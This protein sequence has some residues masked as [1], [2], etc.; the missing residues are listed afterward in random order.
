[1]KE[2]CRILG[3]EFSLDISSAELATWVHHRTYEILGSVDPYSDVK[4]IAME[5][6]LKLEAKAKTIIEQSADR[7]H[8]SMLCS[9]V[10]NVLDFGIA[11]GLSTPEDLMAKF[12]S[13]YNEGLGHDDIE[14]VKKYIKQDSKIMLFIDNC[15]EIVFDKLLAIELKKY[16]INL[17][18]AV[19]GEPILSDATMMEAQQIGFD[20]IAD[21]MITTGPYA[22]GLDFKNLPDKLVKHLQDTDLIISKGMANFEALSET[23]YRPVLHLLRT[24]CAPVASAL[25]LP[26]NINAAKLIE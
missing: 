14:K 17:I 12:D 6:G 1:M 24:K 11:G 7:I 10:G 4:R 26:M 22:V 23:N 20:E 15:G 13:I 21:E 5:I 18:V 16:S 8:T 25:D 9:I 19:K 2:A 3:S